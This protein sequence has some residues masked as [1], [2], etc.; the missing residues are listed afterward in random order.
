ME[1]W[2]DLENFIIGASLVGVPWAILR[3]SFMRRLFCHMFVVS[4]QSNFKQLF[5]NHK[6]FLKRLLYLHSFVFTGKTPDQMDDIYSRCAGTL[7]KKEREALLERTLDSANFFGISCLGD[8]WEQ[9]GM[10]DREGCHPWL[11]H[12]QS[13]SSSSSSSSRILHHMLDKFSQFLFL[14]SFL[15]LN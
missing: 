11:L 10:G 7:P 1:E 13:L 15:I 9:M 3:E 5:Q 6:E 8:F 12:I 4:P 14:G 2:P